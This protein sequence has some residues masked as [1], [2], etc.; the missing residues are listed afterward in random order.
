MIRKILYIFLTLIFVNINAFAYSPCLQKGT[1]IKVQP[2]ITL[3][4]EH[5]EE[6]SVVYFVSPMDIWVLEEKAIEKGDI[7]KGYVSMMKMPTVGVNAAL[8][9]NITE[10]IKQDGTVYDFKGRIIFKNQEMIGGDLTN[11]ASYNKTIHPRKVY[12]NPW[13][14]TLQY[15]P[16]GEWEMGEHIKLDNRDNIFIELDEDYYI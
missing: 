10:I 11:P 1:I 8:K 15:V 2:Q 7:F 3:S 16:S 12:G 13:G 4:S 5:L 6:N 9:I 14:G